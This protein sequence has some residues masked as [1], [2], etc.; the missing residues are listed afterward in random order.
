MAYLNPGAGAAREGKQ[1]AAVP[2]AAAATAEP[3]EGSTPTKAEYD[4]LLDDVNALRTKLNALLTAM[5]ASGQ[6]AS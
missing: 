6:L 3:A 5:R 4:A 1:T 2:N